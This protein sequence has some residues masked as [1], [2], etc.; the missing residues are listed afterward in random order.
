MQLEF[1]LCNDGVLDRKIK[2]LGS[3]GFEVKVIKLTLY[4][5]GWPVECAPF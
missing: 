1:T 2:Q 5:Y 4:A 3:T